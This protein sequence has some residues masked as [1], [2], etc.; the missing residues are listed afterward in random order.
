M[1]KLAVILSI[2]LITTG[3]SS[4]AL[5]DKDE[6]YRGSVGA[7]VLPVTG[8]SQRA[9]G[10]GQNL[11]QQIQRLIQQDLETSGVFAYVDKLTTARAA[12]EAEVMISPTLLELRW[13]GPG[14]RRGDIRLRIK[15]THKSDRRV[16]LDKTYKGSC[17]D[18]K[19][20]RGV[21]PVAGP[22]EKPLKKLRKDLRRKLD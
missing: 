6:E 21:P 4:T 20:P 17:S 22:M 3:C 19:T 5:V 1:R 16:V 15:V 8:A 13:Q 7:A 12:N 11:G 10:D 9:T 18:C 2:L 14:Y